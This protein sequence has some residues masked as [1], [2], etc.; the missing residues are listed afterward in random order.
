MQI[1]TRLYISNILMIAVPVFLTVMMAIGCGTAV[2]H[3]YKNGVV[4]FEDSEDFYRASKGISE[5]AEKALRSD[6]PEKRDKSLHSLSEFLDRGALSLQIVSDGALT[7]AELEDGL[8]DQ[9]KTS[10]AAELEEGELPP[11]PP[12]LGEIL[13]EHRVIQKELVEAAVTKQTQINE[14]KA[15]EARLIRAWPGFGP[16]PRI[17]SLFSPNR[18]PIKRLQLSL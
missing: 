14:K 1:K 3:I 9:V 15:V 11:P 12:P 10:Q 8:R 2:W 13:I 18:L 6:E 5:L 7:Q 4:G 16:D 17:S